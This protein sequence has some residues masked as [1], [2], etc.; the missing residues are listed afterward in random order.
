MRL[1]ACNTTCS[2]QLSLVDWDTNGLGKSSSVVW[3]NLV[4][5]GEHT[6]LV[7]SLGTG[8]WAGQ[9]FDQVLSI[10]LCEYIG[11][12]SSW[13]LEVGIR[14]LVWVSADLTSHLEFRPGGLGV[15]LWSI[16]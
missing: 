3:V 5:Q 13:L 9:V 11:P 4:E 10:G 14:V 7:L 1:F 6:F 8:E 2:S 12:E 15:L 16:E